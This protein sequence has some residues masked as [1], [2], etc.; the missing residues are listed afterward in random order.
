MNVQAKRTLQEVRTSLSPEETIA[1][2]RT[3]FVRR[4][5]I[6]AAFPELQGPGYIT[7]RGQGIEEIAIG[8]VHDGDATRVTGSSYLFDAQVA[9]FLDSLPPAGPPGGAA[10]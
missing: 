5:S 9:R 8:A 7:F 2:A 3:F 4:A 1:A 10:A 6:Y